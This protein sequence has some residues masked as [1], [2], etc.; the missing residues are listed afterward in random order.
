M[1]RWQQM[2]KMIEIVAKTTYYYNYKIYC[3]ASS[4]EIFKDF[5]ITDT[6]K[7]LPILDTISHSKWLTASQNFHYGFCLREN[8]VLNRV[9][10]PTKIIEYLVLGIIPILDYEDIG[11]F[12][13]MGMNY[14]SVKDILSHN[15][16]TEE[17]RNLMAKNNLTVYNN[18]LA[19]KIKGAKQISSI[20]GK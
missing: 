18:L 8:H 10:C 2:D 1:Q 5:Y 13:S 16:P 11:D 17:E 9:A 6:A 12:K 7:F 4:N 14:L 15:I 20:V 3:P 19:M